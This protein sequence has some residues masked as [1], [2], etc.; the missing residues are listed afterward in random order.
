MRLSLYTDILIQLIH[1]RFFLHDNYHGK[2]YNTR[3]GVS[4]FQPSDQL[5]FTGIG[6]N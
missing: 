4:T 1:T 5:K 2:P 6:A 3:D